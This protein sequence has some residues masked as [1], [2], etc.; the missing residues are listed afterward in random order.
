MTNF[1]I[2]VLKRWD[3]LGII[4]SIPSFLYYVTVHAYVNNY[5]ICTYI[6]ELLIIVGV[7]VVEVEVAFVYVWSRIMQS[8]Y[9]GQDEIWQR[10]RER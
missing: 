5:L 7:I 2:L 8:V 3:L 6:R 4:F 9:H 10:L 1:S